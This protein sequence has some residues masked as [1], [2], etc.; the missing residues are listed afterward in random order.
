MFCKIN[1]LSIQFA[2]VLACYMAAVGTSA[3]A[4][5]GHVVH[6]NTWVSGWLKLQEVQASTS[7]KEQVQTVNAYFNRIPRVSDREVWGR[8]DYWATVKEFLTRAQGDC[9]DFAIAKY[10]TLRKLGISDQKLRLAYGKVLNA[11]GGIEP[12]MVLLYVTANGDIMVLDNVNLDIQSLAKRNDLI[13]QYAFNSR[14]LWDWRG[15]NQ[16][17]LIGNANTLQQWKSVQSKNITI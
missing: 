11:R 5:T 12:H 15:D 9:E 10:T 6:K 4:E 14:W 1:K 13:L 3:Y 17:T 16:Q 7:E 8:S 2:F